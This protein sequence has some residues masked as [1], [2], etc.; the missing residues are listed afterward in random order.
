VLTS[1]CICQDGHALTF[2][3]LHESFPNTGQSSSFEGSE[4]SY[5]IFVNTKE[6]GIIINSTENRNGKVDQ[7]HS[8]EIIRVSASDYAKVIVTRK[9]VSGYAVF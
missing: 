8:F 1:I 5:D 2:W 6:H 3:R 7:D 9:S 4:E